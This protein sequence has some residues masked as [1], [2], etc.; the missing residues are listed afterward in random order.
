M[1]CIGSLNSFKASLVTVYFY[2]V[3]GYVLSAVSSH[4]IPVTAISV[5]KISAMEPQCR[6]GLLAI[7]TAR[8]WAAS[9]EPV[10][11]THF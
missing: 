4:P 3:S 7:F 2:A 5:A 6:L 11:G 8:L 1:S 9:Y 10:H